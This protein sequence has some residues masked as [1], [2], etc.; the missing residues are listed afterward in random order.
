MDFAM[1]ENS[2]ETASLSGITPP[3]DI[4]IDIRKAITDMN[5]PNRTI[6]LNLFFFS[7][8]SDTSGSSRSDFR[9][10]YPSFI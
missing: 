1:D 5:A 2:A 9:P 3:D 7:S 4:E 6:S 10:L 8:I